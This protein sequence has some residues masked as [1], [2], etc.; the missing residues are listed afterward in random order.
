MPYYFIRFVL[1]SSP[2][3]VEDETEQYFRCD[4]NFEPYGRPT[5]EGSV[6]S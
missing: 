1:S 6:V 4:Y 5:E 2:A 3:G